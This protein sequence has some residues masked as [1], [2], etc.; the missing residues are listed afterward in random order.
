[1]STHVRTLT[2][3]FTGT[4]TSVHSYVTRP[5]TRTL[6]R[7]LGRTHVRH[8]VHLHSSPGVRS[9]RS[10]PFTRLK[11]KLTQTL[12]HTD[13]FTHS[14]FYTQTLLHTDAFTHKH[15]HTHTQKFH[16]QKLSHTFCRS[17]L[18]SCERVARSN[19]KS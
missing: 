16:T 12:L 1:M 6:T 18:V 4:H 15:F 9:P 17:N 14:R 19:L 11:K 5:S 8:H 3:P 7:T 2:R 10:L 13:A